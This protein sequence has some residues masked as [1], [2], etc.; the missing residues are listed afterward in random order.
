MVLYLKEGAASHT[1]YTQMPVHASHHSLSHFHL[2]STRR[3][4]TRSTPEEAWTS[5]Q[6]S[7]DNVSSMLGSID[8]G[9]GYVVILSS[10]AKCVEV[11]DVCARMSLKAKL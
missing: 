2:Q 8:N 5:S 1:D 10:P 3:T 7:C 11:V 4:P 9:F 6:S